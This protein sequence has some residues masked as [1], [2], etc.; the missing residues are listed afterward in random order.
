MVIDTSA[1]IAILCNEPEAAMFEEAL[2]RDA[3]RLISAPTLL[4]TSKV[5]G[6]V[7]GRELDLLIHKAQ[8]AVERL[9]RNKPRSPEKP[10][11]PSAKDDTQPASTTAIASLTPETP[12]RRARQ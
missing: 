11:A 9:I 3:T 7:G 6:E 5:F 2:D 4:E 10:T 1:L 12:P 8:I